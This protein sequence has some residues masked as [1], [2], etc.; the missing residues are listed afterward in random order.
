MQNGLV[1][2]ALLTVGV[3][4]RRRTG[5][6]RFVKQSYCLICMRVSRA[7]YK[8]K[9]VVGAEHIDTVLASLKELTD[10]ATVV[11]YDAKP[12]SAKINLF[13][14]K[15]ETSGSSPAA[16][17]IH[18][19]EAHLVARIVLCFENDD[20][21][22]RASGNDVRKLCCLGTLSRFEKT[23][24]VSMSNFKNI[25]S[26]HPGPIELLPATARNPAVYIIHR[27]QFF[28]SKT[29]IAHLGCTII[30]NISSSNLI[31]KATSITL[32]NVLFNRANEPYDTAIA[33]LA[34]YINAKPSSVPRNNILVGDAA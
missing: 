33:S 32:E 23:Y 4:K 26:E 24:A 17:Y 34:K 9:H 13:L 11:V 3:C 29:M 8:K 25:E 27:N 31:I 2:F 22:G 16:I 18:R 6:W 20:D 15:L 12:N 7:A 10:G 19:S 14:S 5:I 30:I 1:I 21:D 28:N